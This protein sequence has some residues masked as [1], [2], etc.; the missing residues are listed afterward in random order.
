MNRFNKYAAFAALFLLAIP[1]ATYAAENKIAVVDVQQVLKDSLASQDVGSQIEKK[2]VAYQAAITKQENEL[3]KEDAELTKQQS[4]LSPEAYQQKAKEFKSH[5]ND[6][7]KDVQ[8]RRERLEKGYQEAVLQVQN[9]VLEIVSKLAD[10]KG[11]SIAIPTSQIL[12]YK[13]DMNISKDVLER[14]NKR[15]PKIQVKISEASEGSKS[16]D[17]DH[18]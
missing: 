1:G 4:V 17:K 13:S 15:L 9:V 11:F 14:L 12:Y 3:K 18:Q 5:V 2:R 10:E 8:A 16:S 7:Q 6:V